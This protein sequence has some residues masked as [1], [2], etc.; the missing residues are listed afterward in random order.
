MPIRTNK[1]IEVEVIKEYNTGKS[2]MVIADIFNIDRHTI[3]KILKRNNVKLINRYHDYNKFNF[4]FNNGKWETTW[5]CKSCGKTTKA[6]ASTKYYLVRN[7]KKKSVCKKCS[8]MGDKNPFF[9]KKHTQESIHK[10]LDSQ[11]KTLKPIS[12]PELEI[13]N[14]LKVT[15]PN[16]TP[17]FKVNGKVFDFYLKD[18]NLLIEFNGDYWHCNPKRYDKDYINKKKN[19]TAKEIW[20]Y[21]KHKLYLAEKNGYNTLTI[22]ESDYKNN[23]NIILEKL[24]NYDK[25]KPTKTSY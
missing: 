16:I 6:K 25:T 7:L 11:A 4:I 13:F 10:M 3:L 1:K 19:K 14:M 5:I 8:M 22:W 12:K 23:K 20:E 21:D 2:T 9:N 18:Y 17:Q 24:N 15:H